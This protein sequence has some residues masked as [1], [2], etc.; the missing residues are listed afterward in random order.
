MK[1]FAVLK[2][3]IEIYFRKDLAKLKNWKFTV[4]IKKSWNCDRI[5]GCCF[6]WELNPWSKGFL[7]FLSKIKTLQKRS[8]FER[9]TKT[10][11]KSDNK[12]GYSDPK[13][14]GN[15]N[16]NSNFFRFN[17]SL[18]S[19]PFKISESYATFVKLSLV[20]HMYNKVL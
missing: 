19:F 11:S 10:F 3:L 18:S 12:F 7:P 16:R 13:F 6:G 14:I 4:K 5:W 9:S 20:F 17:W 15:S 8:W 2:P 1:G